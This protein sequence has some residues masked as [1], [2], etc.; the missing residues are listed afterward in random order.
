MG[1]GDYGYKKLKKIFQS[2]FCQSI[3]GFIHQNIGIGL[4]DF[5]SKRSRAK[6]GSLDEVFLG[7]DK[8]W[9]VQ[10]SKD[11]QIE[12]KRDFYLFG[13]RH[14]P[15]QIELT[16]CTYVNIG[17]WLGNCTYGVFDGTTFEISK[18]EA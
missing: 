1:P 8:E 5:L 6:T 18:W 2:K 12:Y 9:L 7:E 10:Y 3:F 11:L 13:H 17:D 16:D 15:M 4:A 14:L